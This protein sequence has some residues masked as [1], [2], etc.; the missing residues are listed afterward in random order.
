MTMFRTLS[1]FPAK[2]PTRIFFKA[3]YV[4]SIAYS[5]LV[6]MDHYGDGG[7][8]AA[9][10]IFIYVM[11]A[12]FSVFGLIFDFLCYSFAEKTVAYWTSVFLAISMINNLAMSGI[13]HGFVLSGLFAPF[14]FFGITLYRFFYLR[15]EIKYIM[16]M[17]KEKN[18]ILDEGGLSDAGR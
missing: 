1:L 17:I 10:Q 3:F 15:S 8:D 12:V 16:K 9:T 2:S 6:I 11:F 14:F 7:N 13:P 4:F 5:L 18:E